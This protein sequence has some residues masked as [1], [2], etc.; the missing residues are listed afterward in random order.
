MNPTNVQVRADLLTYVLQAQGI[1]DLFIGDKIFPHYE[2][3]GRTGDY[4]FFEMGPAELA[5][6][7]SSERG[8]TG[9]YNRVTRAFK[10]ES[11]RTIDRGLE[12]L[13]DDDDR[14]ANDKFFDQ[15][16]LAAQLT[17]R[18]VRLGLE[19]RVAAKLFDTGVFTAT[20]A[21]VNYTNANIAT[22]DF[23]RDL[24]AAID[25]LD[26]KGV[27]ANTIVASGPVINLI[28]RTT[29]FQNWIKSYN[30]GDPTQVTNER[31]VRSFADDYGI[32]QLL[33]GRAS[34]NSSKTKKTPTLAKIWPNTHIWIGEVKDGDP[35]AGGA[36]RTLTWTDTGGIWAVESYRDD[37]R[38]S[39]VVRVRHNTD[40]KV[41]DPNAGELIT[42]NFA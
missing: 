6:D 37:E 31:M 35:Y 24:M 40:E 26:D 3:D 17:Q 33:V 12:E 30:M 1:D 8:S 38:R 7:L 14:R 23:P 13:I 36:G 15:E 32:S 11:Y 5:S 4:P 10:M 2:V 16:V 22:V 20:S 25:R 21:A 29:R 34:Y 9:T 18:N 27:K 39:D 41:V 19:R 28:K 42:T